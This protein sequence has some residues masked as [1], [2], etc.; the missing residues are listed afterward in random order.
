MKG[1]SRR[2]RILS[3]KVRCGGGSGGRT[4]LLKTGIM[5]MFSCHLGRIFYSDIYFCFLLLLR[6][7]VVI[8][9]C[10]K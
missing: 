5:D 2:R 6:G 8:Q 1:D 9:E 4:G 10:K 7:G 3:L